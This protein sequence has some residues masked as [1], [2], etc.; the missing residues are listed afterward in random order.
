MRDYIDARVRDGSY[1]NRASISAS[2]SDA[3]RSNKPRHGCRGREA[4]GM[5]WRVLADAVVVVHVSFILFVIAGGLLARRWRWVLFAHVPVVVYAVVIEVVGFTCPL[6]PLEK[7][8]RRRAGTAGYEGGFVEHYVIPVLY[9]GE[10]TTG[11]K[12]AL[13]ALIV[14]VNAIVYVSLWQRARARAPRPHRIGCG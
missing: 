6:T 8:L 5:G 12:L 7:A 2:S 11:V 1:G 3:T 4:D 9:P 10:F 13:A 14:A